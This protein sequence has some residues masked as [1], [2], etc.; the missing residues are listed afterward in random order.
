M[1][2]WGGLSLLIKL[3]QCFQQ[4]PG[5]SLKLPILGMP[6]LLLFLRYSAFIDFLHMPI[7]SEL[8]FHNCCVNCEE[9]NAAWTL[10]SGSFILPAGDVW[11]AAALGFSNQLWKGEKSHKLKGF[12]TTQ[13]LCLFGSMQDSMP[14]KVFYLRESK[15]SILFEEHT[16]NGDF[17][18]KW[19]CLKNKFMYSKLAPYVHVSS[20]KLCK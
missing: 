7:L 8:S 12:G 9:A 16:I 14:K 15:F 6:L 4:I 13:L 11:V 10:T 5:M 18:K 3:F 19:H 20:V 17:R 1:T 2:A